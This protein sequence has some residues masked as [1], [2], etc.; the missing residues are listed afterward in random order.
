MSLSKIIIFILVTITLIATIILI[1]KQKSQKSSNKFYS[2]IIDNSL[3]KT[4]TPPYININNKKIKRMPIDINSGFIHLSFGHQLKRVIDKFFKN[5]KEIIVI[6]LNIDI[7][8]EKGG[9]LKIESNHKGGTKFPHL[10]EMKKIPAEA[11]KKIIIFN[12]KN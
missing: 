12:N 2:Q 9:I 3:Y 5:E 8:K 4:V 11:F 6:E 7:I 1:F 10:Y